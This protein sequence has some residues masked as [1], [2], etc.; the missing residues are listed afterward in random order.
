MMNDFIKQDFKKA[1]E[2]KEFKVYLQPKFDSQTEKLVGAEALVRRL[3]NN[4]LILPNNFIP[5]Y[6]ELGIITKLDLYVL[7][8]VCHSMQKWQNQGIDLSIAVNESPKHL[9]NELHGEELMTILNNYHISPNKI[10]LEVTEGAV[11]QDIG[12]AQRAQSRMHQLGFITA[13]DDFGVG[14]SS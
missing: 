2:E 8:T 9:S 12:I 13:M 5:I 7:E 1:I 3:Q 6:E 4:K 11:I 14:Y 10:E